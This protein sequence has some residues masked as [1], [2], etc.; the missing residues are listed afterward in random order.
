MQAQLGCADADAISLNPAWN[1]N[2]GSGQETL[3]EQL[4]VRNMRDKV[5]MTDVIPLWVAASAYATLAAISIGVMPQLWPGVKAY[6]VLVAYILA[7]IFAFCNAYGMGLTDWSL[8]TTYGKVCIF[9]FA[10]WGG[11]NGGGIIAGLATA[12]AMA[13]IVGSA[14]DL[15]QVWLQISHCFSLSF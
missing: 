4:R 15:M 14:A 13:V 5:F 6:Y 10:A 12:T 1:M 11:A 9:L 3:A 8:L 2:D 7:P